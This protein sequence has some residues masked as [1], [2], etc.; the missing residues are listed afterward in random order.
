MADRDEGFLRRWSSLK[1]AGGESVP[2]KAEAGKDAP[3]AV[4]GEAGSLEARSAGDP[5]PEDLDLPAIDSLTEKSDFTAFLREGVP[6]DLRKLALR[7]LWRVDPVFSII[8]GL[9]DYD[10]DV[11]AEL[12]LG[13]K[14][15]EAWRESQKKIAATEGE[16]R[17]T[18]ATEEEPSASA[19]AEDDIDELD[20]TAPMA[21]EVE[22]IAD[23]EPVEAAN[24]GREEPSTG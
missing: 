22:E 4:R 10:E 1:R 15:L 3:P 9:D 18:A 5:A 8:D 19:D 13:T 11:R 17:E 23:D 21:D 2:D 7:K 12:E 6:D 16:A 24:G 20:D 14:I